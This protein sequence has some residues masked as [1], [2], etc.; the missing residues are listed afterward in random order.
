[1][2]DRAEPPRRFASGVRFAGALAAAG[3]C[4]ACSTDVAGYSVVTQDKYTINTCPEI[5][6]QRNGLVAREKDLSALVEKAESSPGG[7]IASYMAYRSDLTETRTKLRLANQVAA[8]LGCDAPK[9]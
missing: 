2:A 5:V 7:V 1:M 3:L 4:A 6:A 8:R 9:K